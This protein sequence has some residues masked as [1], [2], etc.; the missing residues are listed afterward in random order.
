MARELQFP[1]EALALR[2][3][4]QQMWDHFL[5]EFW[6]KDGNQ[7]KCPARYRPE[8]RLRLFAESIDELPCANMAQCH[9]W[10]RDQEIHSATWLALAARKEACYQQPMHGMLRHHPSPSKS[11][12]APLSSNIREHIGHGPER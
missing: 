6:E 1:R 4:N 12:H 10:W 9:A 11:M 3:L 7:R 5:G 2:Q 8:D